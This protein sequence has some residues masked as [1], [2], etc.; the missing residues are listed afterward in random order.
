MALKL[1]KQ[2][3][4]TLRDAFAERSREYDSL[5]A[6]GNWAG[7]ILHAGVLLE[8]ALKIVICKHFKVQRLPT[9]F[10]VHDLEFLFYC[11]GQQSALDTNKNLQ[12]NF[13]AILD[14][15]SMTLRYEGAKSQTES[16]D[17]DHAL[18]DIPD[19]VLTFLTPYF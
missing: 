12:N 5:R 6:A 10:Q 16:D 7:A 4:Q 18:F 17:V 8:V 15:W 1:I 11:S 9:A 14:N 13:I 2:D 3:V 19:G